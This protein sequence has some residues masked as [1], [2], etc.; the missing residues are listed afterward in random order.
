MNE[1]T[2]KLW[3]LFCPDIACL[4]LSPMILFHANGGPLT[5][6]NIP[7]PLQQQRDVCH[8]QNEEERIKK[9]HVVKI[10]S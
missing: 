10:Y 1:K 3:V 6:L 4:C 5:D 9:G 2:M 8:Y 7:S